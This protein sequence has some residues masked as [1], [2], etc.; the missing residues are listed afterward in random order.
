M[1]HNIAVTSRVR[2]WLLYNVMFV[3]VATKVVLLVVC[4]SCAS[5]FSVFSLNVVVVGSA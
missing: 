2:E 3:A 4:S 1:G 5:S